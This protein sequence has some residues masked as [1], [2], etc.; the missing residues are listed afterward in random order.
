MW[1]IDK[2]EK[3]R[4]P[5]CVH[6]FLIYNESNDDTNVKRVRCSDELM[7]NYNLI[8]QFPSALQSSLRS[9]PFVF[10]SSQ[11]EIST[12]TPFEVGFLTQV[13]LKLD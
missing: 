3:E 8:L 1:E 2:I 10:R 7:E 12:E 4:F 9:V 6:I 5:L 11:T 13:V